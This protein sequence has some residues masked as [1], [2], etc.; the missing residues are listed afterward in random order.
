MTRAPALVLVAV[1][2]ACARRAPVPSPPSTARAGELVVI[3]V[4][5]AP[6]DLDLYV[7]DPGLE[8]VYYAN[9][10]SRSGGVLERDARCADGT[11]GTRE[12][13]IRWTAPPA[14]RYRV[15]VDYPEA[16]AHAGRTVDYRLVVEANGRRE[17]TTLVVRRAARDPRVLELTVGGDAR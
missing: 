9:P 6:V 7:T 13:R 8:T 14:G 12:E 11:E 16:C 2:L 1:C 5:T 15:G 4:W 3:L 17:E 10:Q